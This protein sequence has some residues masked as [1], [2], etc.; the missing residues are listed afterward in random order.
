MNFLFSFRIKHFKVRIRRIF[1]YQNSFCLII[2]IRNCFIEIVFRSVSSF[3]TKRV[4]H[5]INIFLHIFNF[6]FLLNNLRLTYSFL[7]I[8]PGHKLLKSFI[9]PLR[10]FLIFNT[11]PRLP[12]NFTFQRTWFIILFAYEFF[13]I[14]STVF[15]CGKG[16]FFRWWFF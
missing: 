9:L 11:R 13:K 14:S 16:I 7:R 6:I 15:F 4:I 3:G 8:F 12:I 10:L 1:I 5:K 2:F